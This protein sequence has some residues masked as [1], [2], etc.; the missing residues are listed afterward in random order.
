[1]LELGDIPVLSLHRDK[2]PISRSDISI[3][4]ARYYRFLRKPLVR[5]VKLMREL[6]AHDRLKEQ[7]FRCL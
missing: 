7:P 4:F 1:M 5:V 3:A 6:Y 2:N